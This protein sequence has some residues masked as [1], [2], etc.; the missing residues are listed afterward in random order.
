MPMH[1][2]ANLKHFRLDSLTDELPLLHTSAVVSGFRETKRNGW[3]DGLPNA[4]IDL[5][6]LL[7]PR[8]SLF[9]SI[10]QQPLVGHGVFIIETS[11]SHSDNLHSIGLLWTSDQP[12]AR[13]S[14]WQRTTL[15]RER[16]P[17]PRRD[18]NPKFQHA[19]GCRHTPYAARPLWSAPNFLVFVNTFAYPLRVII[20][21]S[22]VGHVLVWSRLISWWDDGVCCGFWTSVWKCV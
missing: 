20:W 3:T 2:T 6:A 4:Y 19:S 22:K 18:S 11:Q 8:I 21:A 16:H 13:T 1:G 9:L 7:T 5:F 14:V 17:Y 10:G 15:K 12:D